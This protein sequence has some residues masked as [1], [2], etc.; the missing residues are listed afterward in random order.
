MTSHIGGI[1]RDG[2][3][4]RVLELAAMVR[5][6]EGTLSLD[7]E[8]RRFVR[9][10]AATSSAEWLCP[11]TTVTALLD[12]VADLCADGTDGMPPLFRDLL[13]RAGAGTDAAACLRSLTGKLR[14]LDQ[15]PAD[16][17]DQLPMARWEIG[18]RFPHLAG[19]GVNWVYEGDHATL[20][21][22]FQAAVESEHPFCDAFLT[23]LAAE[24][25]S[26]LVLLPSE[27]AMTAVLTPVIGWAT[28][29]ALRGLLRTVDD[30]MQR[31]HAAAP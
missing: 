6:S 14:A 19:F 4:R 27:Q 29:Q 24:A 21:D 10:T 15:R 2:P 25:Q 13:R 31:E 9:V 26:A 7:D 28:P 22:S 8:L 1:F 11:V 23:P 17:H 18:V 5:E 3:V 12:H 30:H 16:D 20:E